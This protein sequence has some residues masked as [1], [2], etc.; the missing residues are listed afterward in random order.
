MGL[1]W[2]PIAP[3]KN[4]VPEEV[5]AAAQQLLK[6]AEDRETA[7]E[8]KLLKALGIEQR[9]Y[10][11]PEKDLVWQYRSAMR[12]AQERKQ[13]LA[14]MTVQKADVL[15][16]PRV[17]RDNVATEFM[18][19]H[20]ENIHC[21]LAVLKQKGEEPRNPCWAEFW[22]RPVATVLAE[23]WLEPVAD[24]A[25][26]E[27]FGAV[28]GMMLVGSESFRGKCLNACAFAEDLSDRAYEDMTP[29]QMLEFADDLEARGMEFAKKKKLNWEEVGNSNED[30]KGDDKYSIWIAY[31]AI[32]WLR[33]WA[34]K[35]FSLHA[36]Y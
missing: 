15:S 1:D 28:T 24:V 25:K 20:I 19:K 35:G 34:G 8:E 33:F 30:H 12:D 32:K 29:T 10:N 7:I 18:K 22:G 3:K 2:I 14:E 13:R 5:Y 17:G 26:S 11:G 21:E 36:W 4:E 23:Q 9:N 6:E 16:I 31:Q 27:G